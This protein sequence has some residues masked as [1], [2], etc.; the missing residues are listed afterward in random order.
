MHEYLRAV[1]FA[2]LE[3]KP[4]LE[5]VLKMVEE[6][7]RS[8]KTAVNAKGKE[9]SERE[10][11]FAPSMGIM[12][13]GE[14]DVSGN[15]FKEY[16]LPYF[17]GREERR[18]DDLSVERHADKESY[19]AV[20]D[21]YEMGM[22]LIFYVQNI[23]D[24]LSE[25]RY[26]RLSATTATVKFSG[27]S[28]NGR[29]LLPVEQKMTEEESKDAILQRT[30]LIKAAKDGDED[31]MESLTIEDMDMYSMISRRIADEDV[32]S[33]VATYFMPCGVECDHYNVLGEILELREAVNDLTREKIYVMKLECRDF[34]LEVCINKADLLGEPKVGRRF[35]GVI[36]LQ[37]QIIFNE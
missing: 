31:A 17:R 5:K 14:Y 11:E 25:M 26:G 9:I 22:T 27:L 19:A 8:E 36:W 30:K 37:G 3:T 4:E 13:R 28:I 2:N 29:I 34:I 21:D 10:K 12:L 18:Y 7:Y 6:S 35:K 15:Y 24:F 16:Y 23:T 20:C 1:G 33:I 32:F